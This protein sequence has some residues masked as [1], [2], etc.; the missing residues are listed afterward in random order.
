MNV[1]ELRKSFL[2]H[3]PG[4]AGELFYWVWND[5]SVLHFDWKTYRALFGTSPERVELL[6]RVAGVFFGT[7]HR[8]LLYDVL[9]RLAR[10]TD[11]AVTGHRKDRENAGLRQLVEKLKPRLAPAAHSDLEQQVDELVTLCGPIRENRDRRMAHSDLATALE[12]HPD[13]LPGVSR[14]QVEEILSRIRAFINKLEWHTERPQTDFTLV[15]ALGDAEVLLRKLK[16]AESQK[17]FSVEA[18]RK[19]Y[20]V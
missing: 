14:A 10:L 2:R 7:V 1:D 18:L 11:P 4:E 8:V 15:S 17:E 12:Y 19:K 6:N 9:L 5:V 20:G 16:Y 3:F 13:P